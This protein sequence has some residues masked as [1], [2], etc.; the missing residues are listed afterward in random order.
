MDKNEA[1]AK[2]FKAGWEACRKYYFSKEFNVALS[3]IENID[4]I[5]MKSRE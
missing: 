5:E 3:F 2:G 1:H 4:D